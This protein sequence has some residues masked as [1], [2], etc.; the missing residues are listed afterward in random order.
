MYKIVIYRIKFLAL[1][2]GQVISFGVRY[3]S[4]DFLNFDQACAATREERKQIEIERR[5]RFEKAKA[6]PA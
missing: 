6:M 3:G 2:A 4:S 1:P 5:P